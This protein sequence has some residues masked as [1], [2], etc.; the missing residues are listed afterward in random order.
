MVLKR[1]ILDNFNFEMVWWS[2]KDCFKNN[3]TFEGCGGL[4]GLI[5]DKFYFGMVC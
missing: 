3:L 5:L 1:L 2:W 4:E